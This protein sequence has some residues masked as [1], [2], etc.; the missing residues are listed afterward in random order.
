MSSIAETQELAAQIREHQQ[1]EA[2]VVLFST[3]ILVYDYIL[4][5]DQEVSLI[6]FHRSSWGLT[7]VLFLVNRYL[8]FLNIANSV[9]HTFLPG[10]TPASCKIAYLAIIWMGL[11]GLGITESQHIA[12][13][14]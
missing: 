14:A 1:L 7:S 10:A 3:V 11:L 5:F 9:W 2:S 6:W 12:P 4:T 8:P 13:P